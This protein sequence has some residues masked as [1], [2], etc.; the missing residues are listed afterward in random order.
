MLKTLK[1]V[2]PKTL[3]RVVFRFSDRYWNQTREQCS[4]VFLA[5]IARIFVKWN[6]LLYVAIGTFKVVPF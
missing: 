4:F 2:L 6:I 5:I 3:V 1:T